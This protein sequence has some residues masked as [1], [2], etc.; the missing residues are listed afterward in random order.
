MKT[1]LYIDNSESHR[2]LLQD[3]LS[4]EGYEV[5]ALGSIE[6]ALSQFT[7]V[8]ADLVILELRQKGANEENFQKFKKQYPHIPWIGYSTFAQCPEEF[9]EW[10]DFYLTKSSETDGIK[11]LIKALQDLRQVSGE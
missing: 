11:N 3:A 10:I 5:F 2:F 7:G 8:E 9:R 6:E 1:I 4:E